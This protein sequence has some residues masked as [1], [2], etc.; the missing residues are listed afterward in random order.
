MVA[1][2]PT[3]PTKAGIAVPLLVRELMIVARL[4]APQR[5][6][7]CALKGGMPTGR[8]PCGGCKYAVPSVSP[9]MSGATRP[10]PAGQ[11][12]V[13]GSSGPVPDH[14]GASSQD[15]PPTHQQPTCDG[16]ATDDVRQDGPVP[17]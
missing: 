11:P 10:P 12:V 16:N 13:A 14:C 9:L 15:P 17:N 6:R 7:G 4:T 5:L 3:G 8:R 1:W 2:H